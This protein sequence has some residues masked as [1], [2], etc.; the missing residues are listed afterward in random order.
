MR[1][2]TNKGKM[3]KS[4]PKKPNEPI[5]HLENVWKTYRMGEV[6]VNALRGVSLTINQGEFVAITGSSGSGKSTMMNLVGCLD[7]PT[8]GHIYLDGR[9]ISKLSES[10]LAQI[11]GRKIGFVFQQFHLIPTLNALENVMLPLEFQGI[12]SE[13]AAKRSI[14]ILSSVGLGDRT[15]H[16]PSQLSGGQQQR[17]A[18]ARSLSNNPDVILADEPTGNLDSIAGA[19]IM[20]MLQNLWK[21]ESKTII[22]VTHD[23][24]LAAH[25]K[26]IIRLK[27]GQILKGR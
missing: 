16:L 10:D 21:N 15:E 1:A 6:K 19:N 9:D 2:V 26:R 25:A 8:K 7:L 12:P 4:K 13:D 14:G 3:E 20:E 23:L 24:K 22:M 11:R 18:I 5:L 27:D 17:V